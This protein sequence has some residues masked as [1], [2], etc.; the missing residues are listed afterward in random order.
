[1][2]RILQSLSKKIFKGDIVTIG[3]NGGF[4]YQV[5][6]VN[7]SSVTVRAMRKYP[8]ATIGFLKGCVTKSR[9]LTFK[10]EINAWWIRINE[11]EFFIKIMTNGN[12]YQQRYK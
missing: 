11:N 12:K 4:Q 6:T 9:C 10:R 5:D 1:M 2:R 8:H 3:Q 7:S